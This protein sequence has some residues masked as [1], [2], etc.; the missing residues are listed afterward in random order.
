[1]AVRHKGKE[2]LTPTEFAERKNTT[3]RTVNRYIASG[4]LSL[5]EVDHSGKRYLDWEAESPK[6]E[7]AWMANRKAGMNRKKDRIMATEEKVRTPSIGSAAAP[8]MRDLEIPEPARPVV[9]MSKLDPE[10]YPDCWIMVDGKA[11]VHPATGQKMLD[12]DRLKLR[13]TAEKYQLDIDVK[14]GEYLLKS[15]AVLFFQSQ[16]KMLRTFFDSIPQRH[17][18]RFLAYCERVTGHEFTSQERHD[19]Q[20]ILRSETERSFTELKAETERFLDG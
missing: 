4:R 20:E 6:F 2:Y 9:D 11:L 19:I 10:A 3:V 8:D 17:T 12:Y 7:L 18:S 14:R 5:S 15:D 1:M 13:L 16:A